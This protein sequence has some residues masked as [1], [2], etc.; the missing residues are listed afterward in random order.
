MLKD[1][2]GAERWRVVLILLGGILGG[3]LSSFWLVSFIISLVVYIGWLLYKLR[4]LHQWLEAGSKAENLPDSNG[5]WERINHQIQKTQKSSESRKQRMSMLLKRF[6]GI[7]TSLP[8]ATVVLT[9]NNEID[10]ANKLAVSLLGID[11]KKDRG[12]RIDNLIRDPSVHKLLTKYEEKEIELVAPHNNLVKLSLQVIPIEGD[13]KLLIARDIS[14]R[15][16]VQQM[17]KNF[18]ANASHELRT[19]LT[20]IAGYLEIMESEEE[21]PE[22]LKPAVESA[23]EQ[24]IRMQS[25]IEDLLTLSSFENSE[26]SEDKI[27]IID[28]SSVIKSS[29]KSEM[30]LD[31]H[32][33]PIN[34]GQLDESLKL[35]G[36]RA[37]VVSICSNLIHNAIRY[38]PDGRAITV[39]W[40][41]LETGEGLLSVIDKG[42]GIPAEHLSHLTERFYRVDKGRSQ[43]TGGTGLGLAIVQHII[44]RHGGRFVIDSTVGKGSSFT[45][46]FPEDRLR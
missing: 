26:L 6:Q 39:I 41:K 34:L 14:D 31:N 35:S 28:I 32:A 20:V 36:A 23:F 24:S 43:S 37:E 30:H 29:C 44:Q 4:Q 17:R 2:W 12:N 21:I 25:I 27:E 9:S 19:P 33:H 8:Y 10:W 38:T 18:I 42:E 45:A 16:N 15:V 5:I 40:K 22:R 1:Y 3:M 46:Y 11:I 13:L 7:I